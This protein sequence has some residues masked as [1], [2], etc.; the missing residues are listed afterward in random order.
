MNIFSNKKILSILFIFLFALLLQTKVLAV[1]DYYSIQ[2]GANESDDVLSVDLY[3]GL[4]ETET[5]YATVEDANYDEV[6]NPQITWESSNTNVV[7][8]D[9]S[10]GELKAVGVGEATITATG[11]GKTD[12]C[13]VNVYEVKTTDFSNAEYTNEMVGTTMEQL[14]ISN[15][16]PNADSDYYFIITSNSTEPNIPLGNYGSIDT[17]AVDSFIKDEN[18]LHNSYMSKYTELNQDLYLWVI[19]SKALDG[20]YYNTDGTV[21]RDFVDFVVEGKELTRAN[22]SLLLTSFSMSDTGDTS[23]SISFT[24]AFSQNRKFTLKIGKITDNDIISKI[25]NNNYEGI[26]DLAEY[27]KSN[28]AIY[29]D[30]LTTTTLGSYYSDNVLFD[31]SEKMDSNSYYYVYAEFDD[32]NGKYLPIERV[33]LVKPFISEAWESLL[34][35]TDRDFEWDNTGVITPDDDKDN[36]DDDDKVYN[37]DK[38][39]KPGDDD[40]EAPGELPQTGKTLTYAVIVMAVAVVGVITFIKVRKMK[41]IK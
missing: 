5:L 31:I 19:E 40:T 27:A 14:S 2:I 17:S 22:Q 25:R 20:T 7:T 37:D 12:T 9:S 1:E 26:T 39:D 21:I 24:G 32:E 34:A 35:Y 28:T 29:T 13:S 23:T 3:L 41:E 8:V 4:H 15:V 33:T 16:T 18:G 11:G 30:T 36:T 38:P 6:A 10:T